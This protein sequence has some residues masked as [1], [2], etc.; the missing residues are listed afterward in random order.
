VPQAGQVAFSFK[1]KSLTGGRTK[2]QATPAFASY[3]LKKA[4]GSMLSN[5]I[6]LFQFNGD[7]VTSPQQLGIG[8]YTLEQFLILDADNQ[9]IYAAPLLGSELAGLVEHPLPL[10]FNITAEQTTNVV[11]EVLAVEEYTPEEFGYVK[12]GFEVV[13][14]AALRIPALPETEDLEKISYQFSKGTTIIKGEVSPRSILTIPEL[15]GETWQATIQL[16]VKK[17]CTQYQKLYRFT[18]EVSFNGS[19]IRLPLMGQASSN[20][21]P[22][23]YKATSDFKFFF[24]S[25]PRQIYH[26]EVHIVSSASTG[27][28]YVDRT[29]WNAGGAQL[30]PIEFKELFSA[31]DGV[32]QV[33]FPAASCGDENT[34]RYVD[35]VWSMTMN[36]GTARQFYFSWDILNGAARPSVCTPI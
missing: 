31:H 29:F 24:S 14:V 23:L 7:F 26:F 36:N 9:T 3:S 1:S 13:D 4:D 15:L 17:E 21:K 22:L 34:W 30:C 2:A 28:G 33:D 6:E 20:W 32:I 18:G 16:W 11:P 10:V 8:S 25:D 19:V 27:R 35:S 5:K 12:F